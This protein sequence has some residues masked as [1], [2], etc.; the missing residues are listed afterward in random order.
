[1]Y[2]APGAITR[3]FVRGDQVEVI[4]L[5]TRLLPI[6]A[7]AIPALAVVSILSGALRGAGD[8]RVPLIFTFLGLVLV[9]L[10]LA[11]Y[12]AHATLTL[13]LLDATIAGRGLGVTGAWYAMVTDVTLRCVMFT[14][15]YFQG[16]WSRIE[17]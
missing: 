3:F 6:V 16:G 12:L 8:T 5:T 13:P 9:R 4:E 14:A 2:V 10:P 11:A 17:V 15:R 1:M 7:L